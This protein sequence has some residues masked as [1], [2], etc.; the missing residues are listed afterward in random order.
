MT[1]EEALATTL[2]AK[3]KWGGG[4]SEAWLIN[5][6]VALGALKLDEPP[7]CLEEQ[8]AIALGWPAGGR[9]HGELIAALRV[10]GL[11]L[12]EAPQMPQEREVQS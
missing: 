6:M 9:S 2:E 10:S 12:V 11:Q 1:F 5:A 7:K 8:L 4:S 3:K